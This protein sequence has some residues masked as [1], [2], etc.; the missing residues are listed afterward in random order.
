M[1]HLQKMILP[2]IGLL[3]NIGEA[4]GEGFDSIKNKLAEKHATVS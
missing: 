4:H 2:D 1:A 3:T